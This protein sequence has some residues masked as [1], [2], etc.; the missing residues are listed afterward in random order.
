MK[1]PSSTCSRG[2]VSLSLRAGRQ[3]SKVWS[4]GSGPGRDRP[5]VEMAWRTSP[6]D[7]AKTWES[8]QLAQIFGIESGLLEG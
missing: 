7:V 6:H 8:S 2:G 4:G 5:N 3:H 1:G